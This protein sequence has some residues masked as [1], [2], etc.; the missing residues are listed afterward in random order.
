AATMFGFDYRIE[1][2]VPAPKRRYGYYVLPILHRGRLVGRLDAK[3]HRA[4]GVFEVKALFLEPGVQADEAL[5]AA[6][7]AA[8]GDCAA[9]HATAQVRLGRC[10]PKALRGPLRAALADCANA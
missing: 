2:Y 8:I 4:E 5:V 7:A 9:W 3:A 1:C 6:L 10:D